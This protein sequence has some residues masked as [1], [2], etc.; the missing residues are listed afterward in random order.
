MHMNISMRSHRQKLL[1]YFYDDESPQ[2]DQDI[3]ILLA[4]CERIGLEF[5]NHL[6]EHFAETPDDDNRIRQTVD[7]LAAIHDS[8]SKLLTAMTDG[9]QEPIWDP[10]TTAD[11]LKQ[12]YD[13]MPEMAFVHTIQEYIH[14]KLERM[15]R[16]SIS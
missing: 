3:K 5:G 10:E 7:I 8:H 4:D 6:L 9:Y 2:T 1:D 15:V 16:A 11:T 12:A 13:Q 14:K